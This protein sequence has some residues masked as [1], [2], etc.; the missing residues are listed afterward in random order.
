MQSASVVQTV[1]EPPPEESVQKKPPP[2]RATQPHVPA[3][4]GQAVAP[5]QRSPVAL[6]HTEGGTQLPHTL[7]VLQHKP[8][9]QH[10]LPQTTPPVLQASTAP[11]H[12]ELATLPHAT[13]L[14]QQASP[15]G[16]V[17]A[18]HPQCPVLAS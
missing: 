3:E 16:V 13:P 6:L 11:L 15:Q 8:D 14:W 5:P 9:A 18:G 2:T 7:P 1:H 17:P 4:P 10:V 12:V